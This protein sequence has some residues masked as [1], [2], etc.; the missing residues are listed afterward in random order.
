M[1]CRIIGRDSSNEGV[2]V[3]SNDGI[4]LI[5]RAYL[6][7]V[8]DVLFSLKSLLIYS[9][10]CSSCFELLLIPLKWARLFIVNIIW[11]KNMSNGASIYHALVVIGISHQ[12]GKVE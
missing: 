1:A 9:N 3:V 11:G 10:R 7:N 5:S 8:A 6:S 12:D 4:V 2:R